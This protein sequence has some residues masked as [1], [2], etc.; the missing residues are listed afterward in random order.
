MK[1]KYQVTSAE[2]EIL[3]VVWKLQE[4]TFN[5]ISEELANKVDW[6]RN[7]IQ[8]LI[9]RLVDKGTLI[10]DKI[11]KKPYIYYADISEKDYKRYE[12]KSF[13]NKLYNG[14][15]NLMLSTFIE[16]DE[17]SEEDLIKLQDLLKDKNRG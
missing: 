15:L 13:L 16:D 10:V 11:N 3:K 17:I 9:S 7:T 12:N 1:K 8:T 6:K 14:S 4:A 2:L 5:Q